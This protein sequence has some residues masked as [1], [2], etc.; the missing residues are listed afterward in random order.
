MPAAT[1]INLNRISYL[2]KNILPVENLGRQLSVNFFPYQALLLVIRSVP[3]EG[4]I[5]LHP[6]EERSN[7]LRIL[8]KKSPDVILQG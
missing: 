7:S 8:K 4:N 5:S 2:G 3:G 1:E 6:V